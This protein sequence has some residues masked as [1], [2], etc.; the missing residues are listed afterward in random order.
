MDAIG[1]DHPT[2]E[3]PLDVQCNNSNSSNKLAPL[4]ICYLHP[5]APLVCRIEPKEWSFVAGLIGS[6]VMQEKKSPENSIS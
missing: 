1:N 3:G 5:A 4:L 6:S 2:K